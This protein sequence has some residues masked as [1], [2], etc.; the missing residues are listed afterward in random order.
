MPYATQQDISDRYS[1]NTLLM[2]TDRD[3]NDTVDQEVLDGALN[4]ATAEIDS[5]VATKY[6]L[7]L[8]TVPAVLV[9]LCVDI[10]IYRLASGADL[11]TEEQRKRFDDAIKMLRDIAKGVSS[12]GI[13]QPTPS[14][15]GGVHLVSAPRRF[16]RRR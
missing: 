11:A 10:S 2:L 1:N 4:D 7:P 8:P 13:A 9:R 15:N 14:S 12:L 5:Y 6:A 3:G 16:K